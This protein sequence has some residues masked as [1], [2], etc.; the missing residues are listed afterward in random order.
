MH[1]DKKSNLIYFFTFVVLLTKHLLFKSLK[2]DEN[3]MFFS[4]LLLL[5]TN[6]ETI[7]ILDFPS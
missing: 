5:F 2:D 4:V 1:L 3:S 7:F 6:R